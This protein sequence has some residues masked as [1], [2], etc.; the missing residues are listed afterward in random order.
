MTVRELQRLTDVRFPPP[1]SPFEFPSPPSMSQTAQPEIVVQGIAA[2]QGIAYGQV[3]LYVQ[4]DLD[5][6]QYQIEPSRRV[7]EIARF[8]RAL[9]DTRKEIGRVRAE[10][11]RNLG[12]SL[13]HIS[14]PTRPY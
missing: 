3:F 13:I 11:A 7:D 12:L 9:V 2:S 1:D 10:V 14:E 5:L 4:K 8:E 6:P